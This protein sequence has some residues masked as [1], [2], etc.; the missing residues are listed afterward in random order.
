MDRRAF[1]RFAGGGSIA[2]AGCLERST[3]GAGSGS[4]TGSDGTT[5]NGATT[6]SESTD[7]TGGQSIDDHPAA[8][9]LADQPRRGDLGGHV[10][11]AFEDP[12][13]P[14]C[15]TFERR[16]VPEI[17][18]R[19][20]AEGTAA[21]VVRTYPVVYPWGEPATQAL[22]A[23]FARDEAAF[24]SLFAHYFDEQSS[25]SS[26][27]VLGRTKTFLDDE[28]DLDGGAV[29]ED[30][31]AGAYDDAVQADLDAGETADVGRTTPTVL[32]FRDGQYV[33]RAS[34]S[35]SY[36]IVATALGES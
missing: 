10:V 36:E 15:R 8:V 22:E 34:G 13:C 7:R 6:G 29:V 1:L 14:R 30:A 3:D 16:T 5:G 35:V 31:R 21:F 32:L 4:T 9:G 27:N 24:W 28:T 23:T 33:T 12:S 11:L 20:V 25:F 2:L 18:E 19:L 26:E 17:R